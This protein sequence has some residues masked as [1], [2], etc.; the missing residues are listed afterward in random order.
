MGHGEEDR[1]THRKWR[2][3][4]LEESNERLAGLSR[5]KGPSHTKYFATTGSSVG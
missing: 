3:E 5:L 1:R 2:E 4:N